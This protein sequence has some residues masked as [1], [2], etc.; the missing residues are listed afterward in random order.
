MRAPA[1]SAARLIAETTR[2]RSH[3]PLPVAGTAAIV[4]VLGVLGLIGA[5]A[6]AVAFHITGRDVPPA[7]GRP[8]CDGGPAGTP[9]ALRFTTPVDPASEITIAA[10]GDVL[11]H[12]PL[13]RQGFRHEDGFASLWAPVADLLT[14]ANIAYANLEGPLAEN[15]LAGGGEVAGPV[16]DYDNRVYTGYPMFNYPPRVAPALKAAGIDVVSTANNH[17]LD[18]WAAGADRTLAAVSAAGLAFTGTRPSDD[19]EHPW[20]A[21][22]QVGDR[23]IAWLACTY[24]T[25]GLP[26]RAAQVLACFDEGRATVLAEI[27]RL[28]ADPAIDA[29]ILTPHWGW[30]Y[31][32]D[33]NDRQRALAR[34]A[35]EAGALAVIGA[36]PHVVQPWERVVTRRGREGF[37]LYSLGNFVSN[38]QQLARRSTLML[39]L[40]LAEAP[41]GSLAVA[42]AAWVPLHVD[43][44]GG[45]PDIR[46]EAIERSAGRG[47]DAHAH[48]TGLLPA[49]NIHPPV[50]RLTS[51][52]CADRSADGPLARLHHG[53]V[54]VPRPPP[55]PAVGP[56]A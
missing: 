56:G 8:I 9:P 20:H 55:R 11:L 23:R 3:P 10:V 53:M 34:D 47:L 7:D 6:P 54:V 1:R 12:S 26:D 49:A 29:V 41:G 42:G 35:V 32:H 33:P 22:T 19:A 30:E 21:V 36:H 43:F 25:N 45:S 27:A 18:R 13:Q 39:V 52:Q 38:Q 48:L 31:R 15:L 14:A 17:S 51:L 24:G 2:R 5:T 37:V 44:R 40:G 28:A 16:E 50:A 4:A 46:V